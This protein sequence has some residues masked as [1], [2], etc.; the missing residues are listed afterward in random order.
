MPKEGIL[1]ASLV[2][3]MIVPAMAFAGPYGDGVQFVERNSYSRAAVAFQSAA[4]N[5]NAAAER[6]LGFMHYR[7]KGFKQS[8]AIALGW[9]ERAA[10]H[11]DLESQVNLAKMYENG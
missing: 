11:G 5:G 7:G 6:Q 8:D 2:P 10:S 9:F 1:R 3:L 4:A